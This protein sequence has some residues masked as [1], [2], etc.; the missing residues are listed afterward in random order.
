MAHTLIQKDIACI[1]FDQY[2]Y[3]RSPGRRTLINNFQ[4]V[5]QDTN[6]F[7]HFVAERYPNKPIFMLG[8]S[9]GGLLAYETALMN[10]RIQGALMLAPA[11]GDNKDFVWFPKLMVK[12]F[13]QY[14]LP[15]V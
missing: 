1:G 10:P 7:V 11:L 3:G 8:E 12:Y 2:G 13:A 5:I 15:T 14:V 4:K 9:M 6:E